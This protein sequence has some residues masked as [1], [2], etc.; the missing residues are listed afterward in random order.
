M[1]NKIRINRRFFILFILGILLCGACMGSVGITA[2]A[3][4]QTFAMDARLLPSNQSVYEIQV[5]V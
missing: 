2:R 1:G 5:K 3:E 4:E